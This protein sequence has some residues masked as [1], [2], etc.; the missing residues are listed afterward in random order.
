[1]KLWLLKM[2][3]VTISVFYLFNIILA[4]SGSPCPHIFMYKTDGTGP[5]YGIITTT[6]P[7]NFQ[8]LLNLEIQI[9]VG[10]SIGVRNIFLT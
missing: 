2:K 3:L 4:Q 6:A 10:N 7:M 9:S 8:G 1:M 5:L